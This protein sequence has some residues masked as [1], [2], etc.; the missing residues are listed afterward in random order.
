VLVLGDLQYEDGTAAGF[1]QVYDPT[2]GRVR[3][4][5]HPAIGN[6]EYE[7]GGGGYFDHF[8][9]AA[10]PQG[11]GWYSFDL[12]AWHLVALN[13]NCDRVGCGTGSVQER[14]LAADLAA[15][16]NRC[17]LAF[18][19][20]PRWSGGEHGDDPLVAPLLQDLY[21][22]GA[23]V[24]LNGHDHD[25]ERFAPLDPAGAPDPARG[26]REFVVGSGGRS[27]YRVTPSA[28]TQAYTDATFGVLELTL[29]RTGYDWSFRP[30]A[31]GRWTD[32]GSAGCH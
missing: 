23:D 4:I 1:R 12:G 31:G 30:E 29:R 26:L 21:A 6:H 8:G 19:H 3:S 22:A 24:V 25:Y 2:W 28:R 15:H 18:W 20:H 10:G 27:H 7:S 11:E 32:T 5:T 13:S 16:P 9:A 14:W 17:T